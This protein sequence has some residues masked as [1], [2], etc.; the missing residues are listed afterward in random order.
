[1]VLGLVVRQLDDATFENLAR[2]AALLGRCAAYRIE[3]NLWAYGFENTLA[4]GN[5]VHDQ[6]K[7][8]S[9]D[10]M[11]PRILAFDSAL[12]TLGQQQLVWPFGFPCV[13]SSWAQVTLTLRPQ[14][15]KILSFFHTYRGQQEYN[16]LV[17]ESAKPARR[18]LPPA[19]SNGLSYLKQRQQEMKA[20]ES[21]QVAQQA[22]AEKVRACLGL[23]G[24][25]WQEKAASAFFSS[26]RVAV[27]F[28]IAATHETAQCLETRLKD[29]AEPEGIPFSVS[30]P[31]PLIS[32][33]E[34]F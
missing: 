12:R 7:T 2:E 10:W 8:S 31:W 33:I 30:G 19:P 16:L 9:L 34:N 27:H 23:M 17:Y 26:Q 3:K 1:V 11:G 24:L 5:W 20:C 15:D 25:Q 28:V 13:F 14:L 21:S 32:F 4:E 22:F 18:E 29:L 6:S